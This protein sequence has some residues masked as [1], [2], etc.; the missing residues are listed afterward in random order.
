MGVCGGGGGGATTAT[1]QMC[2]QRQV[3]LLLFITWFPVTR[4]VVR[5]ER[6]EFKAQHELGSRWLVFPEQKKKL[7][8]SDRRGERR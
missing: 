5:L 2:K 6:D 7:R 3:V 1:T 8:I 4:S